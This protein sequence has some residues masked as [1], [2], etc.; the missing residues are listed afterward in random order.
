[1]TLLESLSHIPKTIHTIK[2]RNTQALFDHKKTEQQT[3][4]SFT[5]Y[6]LNQLFEHTFIFISIRLLPQPITIALPL[7]QANYLRPFFRHNSS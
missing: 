1:M 5:K 7:Q 3:K 4:Q 2:T 6:L